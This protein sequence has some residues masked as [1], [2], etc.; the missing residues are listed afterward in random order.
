[1]SV[2]R[3]A[4]AGAALSACQ[5]VGRDSQISRGIGAEAA[6]FFVVAAESLAC[7]SLRPARAQFPTVRW[8]VPAPESGKFW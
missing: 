7:A 3:R 1:M 2:A 8:Q 4:L 5:K 6:D